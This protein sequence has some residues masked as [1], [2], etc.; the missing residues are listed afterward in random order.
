MLDAIGILASQQ[1]QVLAGAAMYKGWA[2]PQ[3]ISY[4]RKRNIDDDGQNGNAGAADA[5]ATGQFCPTDPRFRLTLGLDL[6]Q[7][8]RARHT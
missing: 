6:D 1:R 3:P 4:C 2:V 7:E 8:M 5:E